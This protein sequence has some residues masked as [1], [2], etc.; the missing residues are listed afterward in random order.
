[1]KAW[2]YVAGALLSTTSA[3]I[4]VDYDASRGDDV[5][6]VLKKQNLAGWDDQPWPK[7]QP[8]NS[9]CFFTTA[10][11]PQGR[12]AAHVHKDAH[13]ARSEYHVLDGE[14][15]Q[16][17]TYY[18]GYKVQFTHVDYQTIVFQRKSYNTTSIP[19]YDDTIPI[20]LVFRKDATG[21]QN[22]TMYV[23]I[24]KLVYSRQLS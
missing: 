1:M 10:K 22:H 13:F 21:G 4:L 12:P 3:K 15:E 17:K 7:G 14:V 24:S 5:N 19:G 23:I 8:Q 16:D 18:I 20:G 9:S 11:D 6:K 2:F